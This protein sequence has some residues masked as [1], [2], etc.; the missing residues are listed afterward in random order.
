MQSNRE[1][2]NGK[3]AAFA[4]AASFA[5]G[6]ERKSLMAKASSGGAPRRNAK[7]KE[8]ENLRMWA[9]NPRNSDLRD[10]SPDSI[11]KNIF[12]LERSDNAIAKIYFSLLAI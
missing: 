6:E 4:L 1:E 7:T 9:T 11:L 5:E 12:Q 8:I 10:I 2:E 3:R